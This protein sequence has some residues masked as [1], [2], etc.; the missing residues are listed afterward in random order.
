MFILKSSMA[1]T[2]FLNAIFEMSTK[3]SFSDVS[4]YV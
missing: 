3:I 4:Q 2:M 1:T